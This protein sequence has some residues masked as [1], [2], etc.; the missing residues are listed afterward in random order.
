MQK[1]GIINSTFPSF[2]WLLFTFTTK[3]TVPNNHKKNT[4][5]STNGLII[6][7]FA[8]Q[9]SVFC[10]WLSLFVQWH[11]PSLSQTRGRI[12]EIHCGARAPAHFSVCDSSWVRQYDCNRNGNRAEMLHSYECVLCAPS[13]L[14][15]EGVRA[16][17]LPISL[18]QMFWL[19]AG[20]V[21]ISSRGLREGEEEKLDFFRW[22]LALWWACP[23]NFSMLGLLSRGLREGKEKL[24]IFRWN[25]LLHIRILCRILP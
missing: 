24:D 5:N 23:T 12:V 20:S 13:L 4:N 9:L 19:A 22:N 11:S 3:I 16:V 18:A 2:S 7:M 1:H 10:H 14:L 15:L 8:V 6:C 21:L 25:F 17:F